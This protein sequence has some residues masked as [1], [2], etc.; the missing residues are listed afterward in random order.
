MEIPAGFETVRTPYADAFALREER[1]WV[2][3][4]LGEHGSLYAG[5]ARSRDVWLLEGRR[6]VYAVSSPLGRRVVRRYHRG[7]AV[8]F[9]LRDRHLRV[10]RPRP[11]GET[12]VSAEARRRGIPTPRV[13]AGAVYPSGP[14][15]RGDLVTVFV[16][17]A[18]ELAEILFDPGRR[19]VSGTVERREALTET[20]SL[21]RKMA[22]AGVHHVDL[23]ARNVLLEWSG[24]AP[25]ALV[26][27]LDRCRLTDRP[28][29]DAAVSMHAR[30]LRSIRKL[31][32]KV[33]LPVPPGDLK[34]LL[35]GVRG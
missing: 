1:D 25:H 7:G 23:N 13:V 31:G 34:A 6:P 26:L 17:D 14:F 22:T 16:P 3:S 10:G 15:Y 32:G 30:L 18:V 33:D 29:P 27:D 24:G 19:G 28:D 11:V 2:E 8:A 12:I 21:I 20:G 4:L 9:L 5:A 35:K